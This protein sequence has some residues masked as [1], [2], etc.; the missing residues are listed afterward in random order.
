M[1]II[2]GN[3]ARFTRVDEDALRQQLEK[4]NLEVFTV[5][6]CELLGERS[7]IIICALNTPVNGH[8]L[9]SASR[10]GQHIGAYKGFRKNDT[11]SILILVP[12]TQ[13]ECDKVDV[14][15][16]FP[17]AAPGE[18]GFIYQP[19]RA[20]ECLHILEGIDQGRITF[21]IQPDTPR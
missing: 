19:L 12:E 8:M 15:E 7:R 11:T 16:E 1:F 20:W 10:A 2:E 9:P 18:S 4:K 5:M 6:V 3:P 14:P 21:S 17:R 13:A